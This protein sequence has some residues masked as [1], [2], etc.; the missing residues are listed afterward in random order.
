MYSGNFCL[1]MLRTVLNIFTV[2]RLAIGC[3]FRSS[4]AAAAQ[5][6][7]Y[8]G[9]LWNRALSATEHRAL[10]LN[11]WQVFENPLATPFYTAAA[12]ASTELPYLTMPPMMSGGWA[13]R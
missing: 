9:G 5:S 3:L 1:T 11:P 13:R 8:F 4:P 10:A 12:A 6:R 7:V 2:D